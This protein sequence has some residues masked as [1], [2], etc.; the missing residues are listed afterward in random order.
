VGRKSIQRLN[1]KCQTCLEGFSAFCIATGKR[2]SKLFL[3]HYRA[4]EWCT[5]VLG[6]KVLIKEDWFEY[7]G[8][9]RQ[10]RTLDGTLEIGG[11]RE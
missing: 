8:R 4:R 6:V 1:G 11:F 7:I 5:G 2:N 9:V 3:T 10:E